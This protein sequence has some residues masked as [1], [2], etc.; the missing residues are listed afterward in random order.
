MF[1]YKSNKISTMCV[2]IYMCR[3]SDEMTQRS[4]INVKIFFV[5]GKTQY[6]QDISFKLFYRFSVTPIKFVADYFVD[7]TKLIPKFI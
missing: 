7:I 1:R 5:N 3:N 4:E 2:C 6:Y